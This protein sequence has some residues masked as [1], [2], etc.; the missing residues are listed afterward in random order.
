MTAYIMT[1]GRIKNIRRILPFW[2]RQQIPVN[3]V[4]ESEEY[5]IHKDNFQGPTVKVVP[6]PKK[7][8]GFGFACNYAVRHAKMRGHRSI[9]MSD[10]DLHPETGS[11]FWKLL[12]EAEKPGVIGIGATRDLH[13]H[14]TK[15][16]TA[17]NKGV[18]LC[19]GGWGQQIYALNVSMAMKIGNFDPKLDCFGEGHEIIREGIAWE[20]IP[21]LVHCGVRARAIGARYAAGGISSLYPDPKERAR[22]EERCREII[23]ERWPDYVSPP[24]TRPRVAW[25][26]M[27]DDYIPGWR[28]LSAMHGGQW[29]DQ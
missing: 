17:R 29:H 12:H 24:K 11:D 27:L 16:A 26:R 28:G 21:W 25:Q 9:I 22:R 2:E 23:Y 15:G 3:L 13:D 10:D 1:R 18:M 5:E 4:V 14:F 6:L 20:A 8:Q 19:P 7:D